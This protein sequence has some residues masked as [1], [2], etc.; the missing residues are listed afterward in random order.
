MHGPIS[1]WEILFFFPG[2]SS[3]CASLEVMHGAASDMRKM[4]QGTCLVTRLH[5]GCSGDIAT[6]FRQE[7]PP[8][9]GAMAPLV[10]VL[11][12]AR[13]AV[14]LTLAICCCTSAQRE[15]MGANLG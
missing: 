15:P 6:A 14:P 7:C 5:L 2:Q 4:L 10:H 11:S 3:L 13:P 12:S 8:A 1:I 9:E